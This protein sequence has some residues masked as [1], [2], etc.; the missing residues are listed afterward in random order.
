[1]PLAISSASLLATTAV[2]GVLLLRAT[3]RS[4]AWLSRGRQQVVVLVCLGCLLTFC[5]SHVKNDMRM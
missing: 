3:F 2:S 5:Q 1:M 4:G